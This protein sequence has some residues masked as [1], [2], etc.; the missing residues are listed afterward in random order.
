MQ[1]HTQATDRKFMETESIPKLLTRFAGP[2]LAGMLC[3]ALYNIVDRIFVGQTVGAPGLGAIALA[4]PCMLFFLS[5]SFLVGMGAASR[6]SILMGEKK[7]E[8]AEQTLGN[9]TTMAIVLGIACWVLG[10]VF[11]RDILLLSGASEKLYPVAA[12]YLSIILYG[13]VF[14]IV[15]FALSCQIRAM[16]S[17][18]YAMGSQAVGALANIVLDA[19]LVLG[20]DMGVEGA[21]IATVISQFFSML[22]ALSYFFRRQ[23]VL[24]LRIRYLLS[25]DRVTLGR[26]LAVGI[27]SCLVQLN[28]VLVHGMITNAASSHGGDLAVSATGIFMSL[29][30]LLFMPA[31]AIAE[32]CQPIVGY[33]YGAG[34]IERVVRT[35]KTGV[36]ATTVFYCLSFAALMLFAEY[37]VM[38]F[39]SD[40][41]E[42]IAL[43]ARAVR[44]ANVGI[45]VMGI[46]VINTSFL[47]GL[48]KGREG[49]ILAAIRFGLFLWIPLLVLPR[50]FGVYGAWG[51]FPVSDI[52]GSVVSG[53]FMLYTIR[54][55]R[56]GLNP[57]HAG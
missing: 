19:W 52:C 54:N 36:L 23:A 9:A 42:L 10:R 13:V 5:V 44:F 53:L 16:G 20:K 38:L 12:A 22:W 50:Y 3:N 57:A 31:I 34:K 29:D 45:P 35:V 1:D 18:T 26:I 17:P 49:L 6:V 8:R 21:A 25:P 14:S 30:S 32:A 33:N 15:S 4:F 40:D 55:L 37:M 47:Q 27:P 46:S 48:G 24:K 39:N 41:G 28:F 7:P 51:S 43:A 2:A 56:A 11:F